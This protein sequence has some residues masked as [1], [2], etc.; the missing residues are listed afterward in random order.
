[1]PAAQGRREITAQLKNATGLM[2]K[3]SRRGDRAACLTLVPE[4]SRA[5]YVRLCCDGAV[6]L[7]GTAAKAVSRI[8]GRVKLALKMR[9]RETDRFH[10]IR[11]SSV[12]EEAQ[13]QSLSRG[14]F[15]SAARK[16][17]IDCLLGR[18]QNGLNKSWL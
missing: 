12:T 11:S 7:T 10:Q 1:L 15:L 2:A 13:L 3:I 9:A 14:H 5:P 6:D 8:R 18:W 16:V 4:H 17:G